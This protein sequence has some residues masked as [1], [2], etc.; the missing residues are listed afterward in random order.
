MPA[1]YNSPVRLFLSFHSS[2][3]WA[4]GSLIR[5]CA[6]N[7]KRFVYAIHVGV[8][9]LTEREWEYA[10]ESEGYPKSLLVMNEEIETQY[11]VIS[12]KII[13]GLKGA[14]GTKS[15]KGADGTNYFI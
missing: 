1:I 8:S 5:C 4:I 13:N 15:K 10:K 9:E 12:G 6:A 14:T 11:T 3:P 2:S 7:E